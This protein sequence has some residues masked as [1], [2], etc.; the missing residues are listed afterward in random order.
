MVVTAHL[1]GALIF[2]YG[3]AVTGAIANN[4][5]SLHD[6]NTLASRQTDLNLKYSEM[7]HHIFG[8]ITLALAGS[9]M[10]QAAAPKHSARLRWVGPM[11]LILGGIFLFLCADLDLYRLTDLRQFR[12]REVQLHKTIAIILAVVGFVGLRRSGRAAPSQNKAENNAEPAQVS[13]D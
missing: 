1:G 6:L 8:Y 2:D 5:L 10:A 9:L 4:A 7:M 12:D 3:A 11:L 13:T